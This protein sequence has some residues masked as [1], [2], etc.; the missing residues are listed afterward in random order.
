M[1]YFLTTWR[2][3]WRHDI[4]WRHTYLLMYFLVSWHTLWCH[5]V[6][7]DV[8]VYFCHQDATLPSWRPFW[9]NDVLFEVMTYFF[10]AYILFDVTTAILTLWSTFCRHDTLFN[11]IWRIFHTFLYD[12]LFHNMLSFLT[13]WHNCW[14]SD[15]VFDFMT[16]VL[17]P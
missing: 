6:L 13:S 2:T 15:M 1:M 5:G 14:R 7:F 3:F 12:S 17:T 16:Y 9:Y 4:L 11:I 8:I 10:T